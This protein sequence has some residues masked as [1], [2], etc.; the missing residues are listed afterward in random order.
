MET[1]KIKTAIILAGGKGTRISSIYS[2]IPK[3]LI[4]VAGK[5]LLV[6]QIEYL[7]SQGI[8]NFIISTGYLAKKIELYFMKN[9][10]D[11]VNISFAN[12]KVPLG[13]GGAICFASKKIDDKNVL[14][15]NGDSVCFAGLKKM[16]EII[17]KPEAKAVILVSE[18]DNIKDY[19]KVIINSENKVEAFIE[20]G[21]T[22]GSGWVNA[23]IYCIDVDWAKKMSLKNFFSIEKDVFPNLAK[24]NNLFAF[25][26]KKKFLDIGTPER[27]KLA[28][29][30]FNSHNF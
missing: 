28:E 29:S 3:P 15:C 2:T 26:T 22:K 10:I 9:K 24:S 17:A 11:N 20:K 12:E 25:K 1:N 18:I 23:G 6:W 13:T 7:R 19:G 8:L 21:K 4:P 27:L 30:F 5:P 14:V 16:I